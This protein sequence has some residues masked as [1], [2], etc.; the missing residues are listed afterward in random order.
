[1]PKTLMCPPEL[2][3]KD[4][5]GRHHVITGANGGI[6]FECARQL[7]KQGAHVILACRR[8]D[9]GQARVDEIRQAHPS[10]SVEVRGLDLGDLSSVRRFAEGVL[11]DHD[12]LHGLLNNAGVMNTP[13]GKTADGFE[14]QIGINHLGH[15]L[16]TERLRPA[17]EKG[18]PSRIVNVSS[19]FHDKAM[20][21][22]GKIDLED[23]Q[24]E[25]R[26]YDGWE[27]YAQS[28][29]ANL[30]HARGLAKRLQGTGVVAVSVHPG[31]VRTDLAKHS[32]PLFVQNYIAR[33][34]LRLAGMIEPWPGAQT[35]LYALL[36]D[37]VV[38]HEGAFY[39]QTGVYRDKAC[40]RGGWPL[41]SP[42]PAAHDDALVDALWERS[43]QLVG[44]S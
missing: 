37:D 9:E 17:L 16:L 40:N 11:A 35:S 2:L 34:F 27:A 29:L 8:V 14:T 38:E 41:R 20:G 1:M 28:K 30:L 12:A 32:M 19:C 23:L 39:S 10:A 22:E 26:P 7:A 13:Q 5:S 25:R 42:N 36:A 43:T 21:R 44:A 6:G 33:P 4:L 15:F 3:K 24:Y 18:A 31:W